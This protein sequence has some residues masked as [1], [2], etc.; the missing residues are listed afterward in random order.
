MGQAG[1]GVMEGSCV[2]PIPFT[3]YITQFD[4][5]P[6]GAQ[7]MLS[8][9]DWRDKKNILGNR[10][11]QHLSFAASNP[12]ESLAPCKARLWFPHGIGASSLGLGATFHKGICMQEWKHMLRASFL[13]FTSAFMGIEAKPVLKLVWVLP[14]TVSESNEGVSVVSIEGN[15]LEERGDSPVSAALIRPRQE[16]CA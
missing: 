8:L 10:W 15:G 13:T 2:W 5:H 14:W 6:C 11:K 7:H 3:R 9:P 4:N 1:R 12:V 16:Y